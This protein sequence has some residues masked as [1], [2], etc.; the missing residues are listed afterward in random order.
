MS[1][2]LYS[3]DTSNEYSIY[4]SVFKKYAMLFQTEVSFKLFLLIRSISI[5]V[6]H[7]LH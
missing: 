3:M 1:E 6:S 7:N 4:R 2:Y 5:V